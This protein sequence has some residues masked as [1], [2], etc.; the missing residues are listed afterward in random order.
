MSATTHSQECLR[1][2]SVAG[3]EAIPVLPR[4][5][6]THANFSTL[7]FEGLRSFAGGSAANSHLPNLRKPRT[8]AR[9]ME[10]GNVKV[11]S[12]KFPASRAVGE[13]PL[14]RRAH[15]P[16]AMCDLKERC[17]NGNQPRRV[18]AEQ[19]HCHTY[20]YP[21]RQQRQ[22]LPSRQ[23]KLTFPKLRSDGRTVKQEPLN[24]STASEER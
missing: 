10:P 11:G 12:A 22:G 4:P 14:G 18:A 19:F 9:T 23:T 2:L 16:A 3:N 6:L 5:L 13:N 24:S 1:G 20:G 17:R 15:T 21:V 8:D 7:P